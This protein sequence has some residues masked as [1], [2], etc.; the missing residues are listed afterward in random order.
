MRIVAI[1]DTHGMHEQL[2]L[3]DG[4]LLIH[5]GDFCGHGTLDEAEAFVAWFAARPHRSKLLVA[6]NHELWVETDLP[7]F[8]AMIPESVTFLHDSGAVLQ[9]LRCWGSAWTPTF[10]DWAF[11]LPRGEALRAKWDQIPAGID[12]LVTHGPPY[13]HGDLAP[14]HFSKHPRAVG[15]LELLLAVRRVRPRLH[16]FGHIHAGHGVTQSDE[17]P[18]TRFMNAATCTERYEPTN[19]PLVLDL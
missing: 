7:A 11:M 4:D 17:V 9:G 1:S 19:P 8:R 2:E 18:G 12:V 15:C 10:Y 13:G 16:V 3:P 14:P 6:G 5:A